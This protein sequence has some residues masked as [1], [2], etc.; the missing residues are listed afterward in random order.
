VPDSVRRASRAGNPVEAPVEPGYAAPAPVNPFARPEPRSNL[1][2]LPASGARGRVESGLAARVST[3]RVVP[4]QVAPAPLLPQRIVPERVAPAPLLPER[5]VPERMTAQQRQ[6]D[7]KQA[8]LQYQSAVSG[9]VPRPSASA[10]GFAQSSGSSTSGFD[11]GAMRP[12]GLA[13]ATPRRRLPDYLDPPV[14][15]TQP[16]PSLLAEP[17][18]R[19]GLTSLAPVR[20]A[21]IGVTPTS[22]APRS[23]APATV[24]GSARERTLGDEINDIKLKLTTTIDI[25]AA[26]KNTGGEA[27]LGRLGTTELPLEVRIPIDYQGKVTLRMTPVLLSAG[28]L[29]LRD[30]K[31]AARFG[32][33]AVG[34]VLALP[35]QSV[36]QNANGLALSAGYQSD[37]LN[38]DLGTTPR[39]FKVANMVGGIGVSERIEDVTLKAGINR[40]AVT[41][42]LLSYAGTTDPRTGQVW[43]GVV[44]N[45][46][47]VEAAYDAG[48]AG[49]YANAGYAHLTGTGVL[50]NNEVE[51]SVGGYMRAYKTADTQATVGLNLSMMGFRNNLGGFTLGH[52]GYFSPQR[53]IS[54]GVPFEIAGRRNRLSYQVGGDISVRTFNV[55]RAPYFPTDAAL[56]ANWEAQ[57]AAVPQLAGYTAYYPGD[58]VTGMG[59]NFYGAFEYLLAPKFALGGRLSFD[60]SR[61]YSQQSGLMYLRYSFDSMTQPVAFPP[62]PMR[63]GE[64]P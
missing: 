19:S 36:E 46:V 14:T 10:A 59:Y 30:P 39:G 11:Q 58:T 47:K 22:V 62:R 17:T 52:G 13:V 7:A 54:L 32:S 9:V 23:V 27:G 55:D 8:L 4:E 31:V 16:L 1:L 48:S 25:G 21:Q 45:R 44:K 20:M 35:H 34:G 51:A 50:S 12:V 63:T 6:N 24:P 64:N 49:L 61:N 37:N 38:A 56:Q 3:G 43:G 60:N 41:D 26:Y 42:S 33:E 40:R 18:S 57:L 5:I 53:Y 29:N 2:P 28:T 15:S